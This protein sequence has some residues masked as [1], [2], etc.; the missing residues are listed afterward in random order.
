MRR[1]LKRLLAL[2]MVLALI[3]SGLCDS[4][5]QVLAQES[6]EAE[7]EVLEE[8]DSAEEEPEI[9]D[10]V[11]EPEIADV[12][13]EPEIADVVEEPEIA[14]ELEVSGET[15]DSGQAA[16]PDVVEA[17]EG[18]EES[19][20]AALNEAAQASSSEEVKTDAK[21]DEQTDTQASS[22]MRIVRP[23]DAVVHTYT[24]YDEDGTTELDQQILSVGETLNEPETPEKEHARFVGWYT[25]VTEG[26]LFD[27]FG[28]EGE[29][30]ESIDTV[31]YA[32]YETVFYVYYMDEKH[33]K[34][35]F[36]Q[37]YHED[38][39]K[40]VVADVPFVTSDTEAALIGWSTDLKEDP[41]TFAGTKDLAI[42]GDDL[43]FIR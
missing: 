4:R 8:Q 9:A 7:T 13:E 23:G 37:T 38:G 35:I 43:R 33:E 2:A 20:K 12:V 42:E 26:E 3:L 14:E 28:E 41:D 18:A 30:T 6:T 40:V 1:N 39:E 36:T 31:L 10:V 5:F 17:S 32:R 22:P 29:L 25:D 21:T 15:A 24:F 11:E 19:E 34:V 16:E 27:A